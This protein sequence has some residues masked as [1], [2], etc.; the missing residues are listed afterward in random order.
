MFVIKQCVEHQGVVIR[1]GKTHVAIPVTQDVNH[2]IQE[3]VVG[4]V[5]IHIFQQLFIRIIPEGL[6]MK[7]K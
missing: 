3:N 2:E 6:E 7:H 1:C 4:T 5:V